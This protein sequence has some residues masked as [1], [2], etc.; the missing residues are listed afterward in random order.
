MPLLE[1]KEITY[2]GKE[3]DIFSGL[4]LLVHPGEVHA[5]LGKNERR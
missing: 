2:R 5:I 1:I 4:S 3:K